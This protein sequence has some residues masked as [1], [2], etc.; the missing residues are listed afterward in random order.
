MTN[1]QRLKKQKG[2]TLIELLIVVAIIGIIASV[3]FVALNPLMRF[4]DSR[5]SAR[6]QDVASIVGAISLDQVDNG[7][8]Y[9]DTIDN[10][11]DEEVY[12]ITDGSVSV[13]CDEQNLYCDTNIN[14]DSDCVNLDFL[15]D[16]G[17]LG[18]IPVSP[19]GE[20]SWS[21]AQ[22][23]YTIEKDSD[24]GIITVRSCESENTSEIFIVR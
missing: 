11:D 18:D 9:H 8:I 5:D 10:L 2:F 17:Y 1:M 7:G 6:W 24:T 13:D 19:D 15:V 16:E 3:I 4:R 20:G 23:G 14:E 22:T 21:A 12:M